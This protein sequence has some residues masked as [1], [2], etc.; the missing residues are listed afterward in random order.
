MFLASQHSRSGLFHHEGC[1]YAKQIA[2]ETRVEFP[3]VEDA[4]RQGYRLCPHCSVIARQF[5]RDR[6]AIEAFCTKH[7]LQTVLREG[8]LLVISADDTAWRICATEDRGK[9]KYLLHESKLHIPY[10]RETTSYEDREY[11]LQETPA[12]SI[13]GYL[14]YIR[15]H[16]RKELR[17]IEQQREEPVQRER[18]NEEVRS[19]QAVQWQISPQNRKKQ[20]GSEEDHARKRRRCKQQLRSLAA[21]FAEYRTGKDADF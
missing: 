11:H 10:V 21:S 15:T 1:R 9:G 13:L 3:T 4:V 12:T 2:A 16:D 7:G 6:R 19:I 5:R 20:G 17:R 14:S 8:E 18:R